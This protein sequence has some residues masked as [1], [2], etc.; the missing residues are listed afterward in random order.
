MQS[1]EMTNDNPRF[2]HSS[3]FIRHFCE[4]DYTAAILKPMLCA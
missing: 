1:V 2:L 3:F 4:L